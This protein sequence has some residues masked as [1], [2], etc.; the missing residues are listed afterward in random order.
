VI[1]LFVS[2]LVRTITNATLLTLGL[3]LPV[4]YIIP[5]LL[6]LALLLMLDYFFDLDYRLIEVITFYGWALVLGLNPIG[7]PVFSAQSYY[8][9][10]GMLLI[11]SP[12]S[13]YYMVSPWLIYIIVYSV[14][15]WF[16][17]RL[18]I[19]RLARIGE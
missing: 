16:L 3:I 8:Q 12:E 1:G 18:T 2:T 5:P 4:F 10:D 19:R 15:T 17:L 9:G 13:S 14:M 6:M 7:A 11:S